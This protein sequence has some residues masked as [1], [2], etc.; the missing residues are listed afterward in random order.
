ML[1][2]PHCLTS[3]LIKL[4]P[5]ASI[6]GRLGANTIY[7]KFKTICGPLF[8][9]RKQK[10]REKI[11]GIKKEVREREKYIGDIVSLRKTYKGISEQISTSGPM[12]CLKIPGRRITVTSSFIELS[13][14][15]LENR[16]VVG[17]GR[18]YIL[19]TTLV[20]T[21][22]LR[23][24]SSFY[25]AGLWTYK[26]YLC[27]VAFRYVPYMLISNKFC[28]LS[29][30]HCSAVRKIYCTEPPPPP[31]PQSWALNVMYLKLTTYTIEH[32]IQNAKRRMQNTEHR[33]QN[34]E[35]RTQNT[36]H[37]PQTTEHRT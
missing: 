24:H 37:R 17:G 10:V 20:T 28:D 22:F 6:S 12:Y 14:V 32:S 13:T 36:E 34:T 5:W 21:R 29:L 25:T 35:H 3:C 19:S 26:Q 9:C 11:G 8:F 15:K 2:C 27:I 1:V 33:P 16:V 30:L 7:S 18:C 31:H 23:P 4:L